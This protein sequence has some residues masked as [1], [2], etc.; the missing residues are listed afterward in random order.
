MNFLDFHFE[1]SSA[2][3]TVMLAPQHKHTHAGTLARPGPVR[4]ATKA[5]MAEQLKPA[6]LEYSSPLSRCLPMVLPN[7]HDR[8]ECVASP[9]LAIIAS[10]LKVDHGDLGQLLSS[11]EDSLHMTHFRYPQILRSNRETKQKKSSTVT[12]HSVRSC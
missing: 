1:L 2:F 5:L 4:T 9:S 3:W 8:G 10:R 12:K 6:R 7:S 11:L